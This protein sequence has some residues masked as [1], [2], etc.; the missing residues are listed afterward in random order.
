MGPAVPAFGQLYG[1]M[2]ATPNFRYPPLSFHDKTSAPYKN[3]EMHILIIYNV[4]QISDWIVKLY[5]NKFHCWISI[6][7]SQHLYV[8]IKP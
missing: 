4:H 6:T 8:Q 1:H 3:I 2:A 5:P 7:K